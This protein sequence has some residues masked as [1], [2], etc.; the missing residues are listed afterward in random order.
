MDTRLLKRAAGAWLALIAF[1]TLGY[2][3]LGGPEWS[4][5]DA[6]YMTIITI[7][8]VGYGEI[9]DLSGHPAAR[10]LGVLLI[11][12]SFAVVAVFAAALTAA[13]IEGRLSHSIRRRRNMK[14]LASIEGHQILCGLGETGIAAARELRATG[15]AFVGIDHETSKVEHALKAVGE[16]PHV[17]ATPPWRTCSRR[18]AST[19]PRGSWW[20][21]TTIA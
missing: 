1:G 13:I 21:A 11:V 2:H 10:V 18:R 9:H 7:A 19:T 4:W 3:T 8:S 16:F 17:G 5:L 14:T 12:V 6:L 20:P 15:R